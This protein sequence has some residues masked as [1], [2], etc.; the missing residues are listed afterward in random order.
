[1]TQPRHRGRRSTHMPGGTLPPTVLS[2][3][4]PLI[5][6]EC[7]LEVLSVKRNIV[8]RNG[9]RTRIRQ[10]LKNPIGGCL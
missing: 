4:T 9:E 7:E 2:D 6:R 10:D 5:G 1:M 8:C 3:P